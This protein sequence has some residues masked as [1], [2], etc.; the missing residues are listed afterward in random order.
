MNHVMKTFTSVLLGA[1]TL[2]AL[3]TGCVREPASNNPNF[4]PD[5][6]T[7]RTKFVLNINP[8]TG[9]GTKMTAENVQ[10]GGGFL[11]MQD[12]HILTYSMGDSNTP[13]VSGE[14][15]WEA[16]RT[17]GEGATVGKFYFNPYGAGKA[18]QDY[19][20]GRLFD[21][22]EVTEQNQSR[23]LELSF[24]LETNVVVL[25]G[26]ALNTQGPENQG[27]V[28]PSG[29]PSNL[30][31]LQFPLTPRVNP[32]NKK[33]YTAGTYAFQ[34]I[35]S[36]LTIAGL[37]DEAQ[38]W[39]Q[40]GDVFNAQT[41]PYFPTGSND[42]RYKVWLPYEPNDDLYK[43]ISGISTGGDGVYTKIAGGDYVDGD[44]YERRTDDPVSTFTY[45]LRVG[46]CSWK[47]LGD[48]YEAKT[49]ND[50]NT[51]AEHVRATC[52]PYLGDEEYILQ[53]VPLLETLGEAY[54]KLITIAQRT[55]FA[56]DANNQKII[57]DNTDPD[58]PVYKTITYHELRAGSAA[59]IL[60]TLRD[61][62]FIVH[63]VL[64]GKPT[65]WSEFVAQKLAEEIHSRMELYFV[66]DK[67]DM[68]FKNAANI[69]SAIANYTGTTSEY[70][71]SG[72]ETYF[73]NS[74]LSGTGDKL[75]G[76]AG[77]PMNIGFPMGAAYI[78]A[79]TM[80]EG[81]TKDN[82]NYFYADRFVYKENIPAYA[83]GSPDATFNIFNYCYPAELMY[84][85]NSP[86]RISKEVHNSSDFPA[87]I[88]DWR[89]DT[90][91]PSDWTKF[92]A[93]TSETR[94]V[95]MVD[96]INYGTALL[97]SHVVYGSDVETGK[98][99][100]DNNSVI[101]PNEQDNEVTVIGDQV[102][103]GLV[104]TGIV[105]G[106]QPSAVTWD[107]TRMPDMGTNPQ[108]SE[109]T[110][111]SYQNV[112]F[113]NGVFT[114]LSYEQD[115]FGKMIY[116]KVALNDRFSIKGK[117]ETDDNE[118]NVYTLC[119]DNYNALATAADQSDVYI[120]LELQ[121]KT[122]IDFWGETNLVRKDAIFYLVGKLDLKSIIGATGGTDHANYVD[123]ITKLGQRSETGY[124]YYPPFDPST[125][126]TIKVPRVFM[127]DYMTTATL[128]LNADALKHAYMSVPDLRS[129]QVSLGVSVDVTWETGLSF[130]V[131]MGVIR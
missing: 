73:A 96:H 24:P 35:L 86:L 97:K 58:H 55:D 20:F 57:E 93:V 119:W 32:D 70:T 82:C 67:D 126:E 31:S 17:T 4:D 118:G 29:D 79:D 121:N 102:N 14:G 54:H 46:N 42:K 38:Y 94:S 104:V 25:Y 122:G 60:R 127:Q 22:G 9:D 18:T 40:T 28:T 33:P 76:T 62:D 51:T 27:S 88:V 99:L 64:D 107:F 7:V 95:A 12:V 15:S 50:A 43:K 105:I 61:L 109:P 74:Y 111:P 113:K 110:P 8:K 101:H 36:S 103:T 68:Y 5:K 71:D 19:N 80:A 78:D 112:E 56:Y 59:A 41:N 45:T 83:F 89:T 129:N 85:G 16:P 52:D 77:F 34:G 37:V 26:K 44:T 66:G 92:G 39:T 63:K 81:R 53:F 90:E 131:E 48:M 1:A 69:K 117:S 30:A 23:V 114:G 49:D 47:M 125:G 10:L 115:D 98:K 130:E 11:G 128:V 91:W 72:I 106:G 21:A 65:S 116:D 6:N 87:K 84:Y 13:K 75:D 123:L 120:A 100:F 3:S 108:T 2:V 124:Y